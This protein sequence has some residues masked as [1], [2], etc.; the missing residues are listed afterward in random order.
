MSRPFY[1]GR[2]WYLLTDSSANH[3]RSFG[4]Q[5]LIGTE[6][7]GVKGI[8]GARKVGVGRLGGRGLRKRTGQSRR[9]L[10]VPLFTLNLRHIVASPTAAVYFKVTPRVYLSDCRYDFELSTCLL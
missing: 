10:Q 8:H 3:L 2:C 7:G 4:G 1:L 5:L 6:I 9:A